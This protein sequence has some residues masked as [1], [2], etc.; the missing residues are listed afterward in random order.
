MSGLSWHAEET[1]THELLLQSICQLY[2]EYSWHH[3][4]GSIV[5][6]A[7]NLAWT[8]PEGLCN[9]KHQV[10]S[11]APS[12]WWC[13]HLY[14]ISVASLWVGGLHHCTAEVHHYPCGQLNSS[15]EERR[16]DCICS[17]RSVCLCSWSV[18]VICS[19]QYEVWKSKYSSCPD[20]VKRE[21]SAFQYRNAFISL[22]FH[23]RKH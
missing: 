13:C 23:T 18:S 20:T 17:V 1:S 5:K 4:Y 8:N 15:W 19:T 6:K 12:T 22:H 16:C 10:K 11:P 21:L 2:Y 9:C 14:P 3:P 7:T